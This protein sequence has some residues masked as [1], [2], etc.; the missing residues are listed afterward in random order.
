MSTLL[1]TEHHHYTGRVVMADDSDAFFF[2]E[3]LNPPLW[4]ACQKGF[5]DLVLIEL[6]E[7]GVDINQRGG[8]YNTTSLMAAS[9]YCRISTLE[10]LLDSHADMSLR[11]DR[12]Y[13][14]SQLATAAG[15]LQILSILAIN[16]DDIDAA[17]GIPISSC[18]RGRLTTATL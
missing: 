6:Q 4:E 18:K 17:P 14:A 15:H 16:G 8:R 7:E 13:T 9:F 3:K 12:G 1:Y 5:F 10:L 11:D 2:D